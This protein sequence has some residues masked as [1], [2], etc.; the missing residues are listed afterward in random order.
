MGP[1]APIRTMDRSVAVRAA[2]KADVLGVFI[3]MIPF[4]G[5]VLTGSLAIFFYRRENGVP[6]PAALGSRLGGAA[7]AGAFAI[8]APMITLPPFTFPSQHYNLD[9]ILNPPH[10]LTPIP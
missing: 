5:I 3:G 6:P 4:L 1:G 8:N 2:L 9:P 7:G 10:T